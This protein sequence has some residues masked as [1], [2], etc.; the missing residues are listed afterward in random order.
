MD[1]ISVR[2][3]LVR[4]LHHSGKGIPLPA[5]RE[6]GAH[7][8]LQQSRNDLAKSQNLFFSASLVGLGCFRLPTKSKDVNE[9]LALLFI[10]LGRKRKLAPR[11]KQLRHRLLRTR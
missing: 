9:H 11:L 5:W 3:R 2:R 4:E 1:R 10:R 7:M 6:V 8:R